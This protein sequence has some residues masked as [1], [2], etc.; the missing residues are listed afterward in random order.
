MKS[1]EVGWNRERDGSFTY[2]FTKIQRDILLDIF[3]SPKWLFRGNLLIKYK[4][5]FYNFL[6]DY[7]WSMLNGLC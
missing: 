7:E 4:Q 3:L 6:E 5:V 1:K 2:V